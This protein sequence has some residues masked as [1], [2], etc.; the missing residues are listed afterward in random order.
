MLYLSV[1]PLRPR[2]LNSV[3]GDRMTFNALD[4]AYE[5]SLLSLVD[6]TLLK[7]H[8]KQ[9]HMH[10]PRVDRPAVDILDE[11]LLVQMDECLLDAH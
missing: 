8:G 6:L 5:V 11:W 2:R 3:D 7:T 4:T 1:C 9:G 10:R